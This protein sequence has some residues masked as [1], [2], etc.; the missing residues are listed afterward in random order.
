VGVR[1]QLVETTRKV[2]A[3]QQ[4]MPDLVVLSAHDPTAAQR[5][6]ER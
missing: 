2:L 3:L 1:R 6:L 4:T 5:L